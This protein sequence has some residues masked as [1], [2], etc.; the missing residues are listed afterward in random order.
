MM[1]NCCNVTVVT[2][3]VIRRSESVA[4]VVTTLT[5]GAYFP[6]WNVSAAALH[7]LAAAM[8]DIMVDTAGIAVE[9]IV[10]DDDTQPQDELLNH[11]MNPKEPGNFS[12]QP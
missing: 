10:R 6:S 1:T 9:H 2:C 5:D 11:Q 12:Q 3:K 4:Q 7:T 8:V